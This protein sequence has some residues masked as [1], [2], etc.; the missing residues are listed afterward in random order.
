MA[1]IIPYIKNN[2]LYFVPRTA[3]ESTEHAYLRCNFIASQAPVT[4]EQFNI[5]TVYSHIYINN[6]IYGA[7]YNKNIMDNF[8]IM[9]KKLFDK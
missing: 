3:N 2:N 6:S 9:K 4:Q 1:N 7:T 8:E 5:A